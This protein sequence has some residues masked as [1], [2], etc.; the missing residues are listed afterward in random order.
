VRVLFV[1]HFFPPE[2]LSAAFLTFEF[3]KALV[4]A[5]HEV[6]VLT[7]FPNWPG[8][9]VFSSY[10]ARTFTQEMM[11][12]VNVHRLPFLPSPN[13]NF[14]QRALDFKSFQFLAWTHGR[15]LPRP[16][17][18]YVMA[19]P[20]EDALVARRL[21][22][23]FDS[24]YVPNI[25][26]VQPDTAIALGYLKN[27]VLISLLRRQEA[28]VYRGAD[29]V[30]A[31]GDSMRRR[32]IDKGIDANIIEVLP[33]WINPQDVVPLPRNN[34]LRSEWQIAPERFV[35][36]YAGTFG[37]IH[38]VP[39][40]LRIAE[41]L[42]DTTALF[43][44]VGQGY[45]FEMVRT[46]AHQRQL[47]NVQVRPFVPRS[48]LSEMQALAD[49]SVV[50]VRRGYGHTSVPSKVL[51]YMSAGRPVL[52]AVDADCDTA[53][54]I[55]AARCGELIEPDSPEQL[56]RGIRAAM[57][58]PALLAERGGNARRFIE[59]NLSATVVLH[60]G[61]VMLEEIVAKRQQQRRH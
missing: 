20:N 27:P 60:R 47:H 61:V 50:L 37:R 19:P 8:G 28:A 11:S 53:A 56:A 26:D 41:Q 13:G 52:G 29:R 54:A 30:V 21:A 25:Q 1:S 16:D 45:D 51:G 38:N 55:T 23:H 4:D 48:R 9:K 10:T 59:E 44:L 18:V 57:A 46:T 49:L 39:I 6:D 3:A 17:L 34:S 33:N 43:L 35:V 58:D 36:L 42:R 24:A 31:I 40:L 2:E 12:G 7:G 15:R 32:L 22:K 5:G 14:L